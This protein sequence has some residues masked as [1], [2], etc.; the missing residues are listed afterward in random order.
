MAD[1]SKLRLNFVQGQDYGSNQGEYSRNSKQV[2]GKEIWVAQSINRMIF[3]AGNAWVVTSTDYMQQVLTGGATGGLASSNRAGDTPYEADW[4]PTYEVKDVYLTSQQRWVPTTEV[5]LSPS[6]HISWSAP[7]NPQGITWFY[8]EVKVTDTAPNT[9]YMTNGFYGGYMGIQDRT[10]KWVIFSI[11]DKTSTDDDPNASP[12]D[13]VKLIAK[14]AGVTVTRFGGEG[15]GG[16]SYLEY[17][18]SVGNTYQLMVNVRP[19]PEP[20]K[21]IFTGWFRIPELNIWRMLASFQVRPL[22]T[23]MKLTGLYSFIEDWIGNGFRRQGEWGPTWIKTDTGSWV[24]A[25]KG[26]GTTTNQS[27]KN[28]NL[29]LS[30]DQKRIGM[31]TGGPA[32]EDTSLGPYTCSN[33][34][35]PSVLSLN[36]L[37]SNDGDPARA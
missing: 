9:Y 26:S 12:D 35:L 10:P 16:K 15:T 18:W 31:T 7:S 36:P 32:L 23:S 29:F 6:V 20:D 1:V 22:E 2:R 33:S 3:Y 11:W 25:T 28:R 27:A 19:S 13:L 5:F 17:N 30:N 21:A 34:S 4:G 24:Q 8:T 14:G 37:P